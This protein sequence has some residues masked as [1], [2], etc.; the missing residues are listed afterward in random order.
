MSWVK[1][2]DGLATHP[3]VLA[4]G[5]AAAW[6]HVAGLCY[7]AQH[8][9]DGAIP[10]S[11]LSGLGQFTRG[12]VRK[13]AD[14]LVEVGLWERNGAGYAIHDYLDYNPSRSSVE[15]RRKAARERMAKK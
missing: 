5:Q 9:T 8:L 12:R 15:E 1:V 3:K 6:L 10:D 7:A 4:A 14:R 2:S 11:S 13:L